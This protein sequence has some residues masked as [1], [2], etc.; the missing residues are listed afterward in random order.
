MMRFDAG[1]GTMTDHGLKDRKTTQRVDN[2]EGF[3]R[4]E[5]GSFI[6]FGIAVF[7][8]MCLAG[9][10]AVDTMRYETHR[11]HVQGT[12]DRAIL[13]A[14]SLDQDL[15]P[16]EVVLDYFTKAGLGHVISQDDIDVFEN[17]TNGEVADDVAVTTRRVEASVSAL[18][19]TTFLRLAHMYD[20]GLYTEGGAEEALSLSEISLVLDVSGSMGNSSSSGYSKIYELRRAA[21]RFVNVMLCNPADADE[22]EDCTLT[23]GDISINIVPY[24]EQV[25]LPSNLLQR[26]NHTSEHT[27]SRCI[28]FYEDEFDTVAVPTFSLDTFVTNGRPLPA[29]YGDPIQLTGYFDPSGGTNSTPNPGSNSPCYNDYSGSTNDYWRE[30]YPMGFSAE[31]LRDEID[32]LGASGNT[33]IDLGMKWGAALL[34]PAAQPA[35]SD[36]VAANEVNEAFDGR[37]FEYT[38][39]GIEK[40][41]V[42]MTD[43]E[44]TSQDYLRRGYHS[45]PSGV[46]KANSSNDWS[47]YDA[48]DD[49]YYWV[50]GGQWLDHPYGEGEY[51]ECHSV[52]QYWGYWWWQY[53]WVEECEMVY[54]GNGATQLTFPQLWLQKTANWY[55]QWNFLADAHDYFNYSEKN[56]NLDEI[57]T[58]AKNAGM[59]VFT[60]GFEVSGSQH[61]IMRS[62][63]SA[64]AYYFDVDGLDIS[65]AFAAIARE[66]SKLRLV[67]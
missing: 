45:G 14:A 21:K 43:G 3:L 61:D 27:E 63:A 11:V 31:A 66:I 51:E 17:Q 62:C 20:L 5:R 49:R 16:E 58:A 54:E 40:V 19:P 39:R 2:P 34:D 28:T 59:V 30:I 56:D 15:D 65:A 50:N 8:L 29:L 26:F 6:I 35:I 41:I 4:D 38:Q 67:F 24:A 10:I 42:L 23:E 36:L 18:M 25:L 1:D 55:D 60:I 64:P 57:C 7:M 12:L 13:A 9:G 48:D 53:N 46:Y 22:T 32:D 33:S 44:N 37:P 47:V 52:R